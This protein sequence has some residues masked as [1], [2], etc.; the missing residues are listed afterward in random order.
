MGIPMS[1]DVRA[2][3]AGCEAEGEAAAAAAVE[4][5][6]AVLR[7]ADIRFSPF[8]VDS[9]LCRFARS[10]TVA[11]ADLVEILAIGER[12]RVA[13]GGAFSVRAPDG[14]L[15]TNGVVKG[16]AAQRAA[17]TLR[18]HGV[19]SFCLN[20][21]GDVVTGGEP[22]PGRGW[23][24]GVRDPWDP[25][26]M[27]AVVEQRDGAVATSGTYERGAHVWDGRTGERSL[28][29]V[30]ATVVAGDL[31]T[32]DVLATCVLVLGPQ[33][34]GW[35]VEQGARQA[36]AVLPDGRIVTAAEGQ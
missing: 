3:R 18:E 26:R 24:T 8:R 33:S 17:E 21:G 27:L 25:R 36:F 11:S 29:L 6:F 10:E 23:R 5:A 16:W 31:T 1:I 32:A 22:E 12:A 4:A 28:P 14:S 2:G 19:T 7:S 34:L 20:A 13:S 35:A 15:D 9:E 30:A